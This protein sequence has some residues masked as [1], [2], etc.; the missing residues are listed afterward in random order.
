MAGTVAGSGENRTGAVQ[1]KYVERVEQGNAEAKVPCGRSHAVQRSRHCYNAEQ[2]GMGAGEGRTERKVKA[3]CVGLS[4]EQGKG[5]EY[6]FDLLMEITPEHFGNILK[7]RTGKFQ[8][9]SIEKPDE[10]FGK[11][12]AEWLDEGVVA[13]VKEFDHEKKT[14]A[15][16]AIAGANA[17]ELLDK[18]LN[19]AKSYLDTGDISQAT[20]DTLEKEIDS[21]LKQL[22]EKK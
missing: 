10:K 16:N 5:I 7:D 15:L 11:Q 4:P 6:E 22:Q 21:K 20:Y 18:L 19:T 3:G 1:G 13:P 2:N 17:Q 8:D 14:K 12:L 9:K